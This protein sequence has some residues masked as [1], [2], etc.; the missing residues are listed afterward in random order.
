MQAI[1]QGRERRRGDPPQK[2]Q[3]LRQA[4]ASLG[5][6][7]GG[8][9]V[10]AATS[11]LPA[12]LTPPSAAAAPA[13]DAG[14]AGGGGVPGT[15]DNVPSPVTIEEMRDRR[16][17][18]TSRERGGTAGAAPGDVPERDRPPGPGAAVAVAPA[19]HPGLIHAPPSALPV[20]PPAPAPPCKL[21]GDGSST[22][23]ATAGGSARSTAPPTQHSSTLRATPKLPMGEP[24]SSGAWSKRTSSHVAD[25]T[26]QM[27]KAWGRA[28]MSLTEPVPTSWA[29]M[30][31][32]PGSAGR[33]RTF[34]KRRKG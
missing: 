20:G 28:T 13:T 32:T 34:M 33:L 16:L 3:G 27:R 7:G 6:S 25:S 22:G 2:E 10:G 31:K 14:L 26:F 4:K 18:A 17:A 24:K 30:L 23:G 9:S 8:G 11:V 21:T 1:A 5:G 15:P 19:S 29:C 12:V